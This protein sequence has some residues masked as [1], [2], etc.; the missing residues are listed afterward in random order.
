[1]N[2][3]LYVDDDQD[4]QEVFLEAVKSI[5]ASLPCYVAS[6]ANA[7]LETLDKMSERPDYIFLDLNMPKL[8]G[9]EFLRCLR[10]PNCGAI[11]IWLCI[12]YLQIRVMQKN[13]QN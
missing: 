4:D 2:C 8:D 9:K 11:S 10:N 12:P 1:M 7:A 13:G 5:N 6:D 3:V